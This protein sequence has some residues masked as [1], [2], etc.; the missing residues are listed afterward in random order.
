M[1]TTDLSRRLPAVGQPLAMPV[2]SSGVTPYGRQLVELSDEYG[3]CGMTVAEDGNVGPHVGPFTI[4]EAWNTSGRAS[5]TLVVGLDENQQPETE[6]HEFDI[7]P[8]IP[9]RA[10]IA[11]FTFLSGGKILAKKAP[12][13]PASSV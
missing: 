4:L 6:V 9:L 7:I 8:G 13:A 12:D 10:N 5:V 3:F 11:A 2:A 1:E